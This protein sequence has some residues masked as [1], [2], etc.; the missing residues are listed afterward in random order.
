M[1]EATVIGILLGIFSG[2]IPG[3][4]NFVLML[5]V[6]PFLGKFGI[7]ELLMLY[8]AMA[9][10]KVRSSATMMLSTIDKYSL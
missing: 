9:R 2:L 5:L 1:I 7:V 4:G 10:S 8:T 3:V 6:W